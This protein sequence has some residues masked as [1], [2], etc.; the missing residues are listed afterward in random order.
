MVGGVEED[1]APFY[2]NQSEAG[3]LHP[4]ANTWKYSDTPSDRLSDLVPHAGGIEFWTF[5]ASFDGNFEATE[6]GSG[7]HVVTI[8]GGWS[9]GYTYYCPEPGSVGALA[10]AVMVLTSRRRRQ[11]GGG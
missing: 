5:L 8:Y 9:W 3:I 4:D 2:Y 10:G 6:G 11:G 7:S 1:D